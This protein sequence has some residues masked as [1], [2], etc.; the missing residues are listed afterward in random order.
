MSAIN[1]VIQRLI[2]ISVLFLGGAVAW[3][4]PKPGIIAH[5]GV[6]LEAPENTI[7]AMQRAIALGAGLVEIDCRY[8]KDGQVI[9]M[10]E[11]TLD[12]T[13][14]GSGRV[15]EKTLSE[16]RQLDAGSRYNKK[17]AGTRVPTLKEALQLARGKIQVYLDLKEVDPLPVV[18]VVREMDAKSYV[19][20]RPY[21]FEA[22]KRIT[23][24][25]PTFRV[26][27]D[28]DDWMR[29]PG[30]L[31]VLHKAVPTGAFSGSLHIWNPEML[32]EARRLGVATFVNVLGPEDTTTNL[33]HA[34]SMGFDWIQTDHQVDLKQILGRRS[35]PGTGKF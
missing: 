13:T 28:L 4:M 16:I 24:V 11:E 35:T 34:A 12:K 30:I 33:E 17:Y 32:A 25:D 26:L 14:N 9:L 19:Y 6:I 8:T 21:Y 23:G 31:P 3:A 2:H 10:H 29:V 1:P 27:I 18:N 15:S 20:F 22:L 7:P 5:R